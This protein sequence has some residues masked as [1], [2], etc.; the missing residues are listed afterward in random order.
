MDQ[1]GKSIVLIGM[2]GAGKSSVG[3]CLQRRTGADLFDTDDAVTKKLG[4]SIVEIFKRFGEEK[5]RHAETEVLRE[6]APT[7]PTIFVTG[8]GAILRE[9]NVNLL[10]RLGFVVWLDADEGT[11]CERATRRGHRPL[12]Q[13]ENPRA[14]LAALVA[15]RNPLYARAADLRIDTST[16]DHDEVADIVLS[17]VQ[18]LFATR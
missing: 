6:L 18:E 4:L 14:R 13:T 10:K 8:G 9:E 11:L 5:F 1:P 3:R 16:M 15:E 2:M 12:L 7:K 17:K